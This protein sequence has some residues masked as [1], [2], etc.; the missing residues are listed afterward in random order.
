MHT[1]ER[2]FPTRFGPTTMNICYRFSLISF[3][4]VCVSPAEAVTLDPGD[5]IVL[6]TTNDAVVRVRPAEYDPN[7]KSANQTI[8]SDQNTPGNL[9]SNPYDVAIGDTALYVTDPTEDIIVRIDIATGAHSLVNVNVGGTPLTPFEPR[10]IAIDS[11]G[12]LVVADRGS[13]AVLE[14]DP[15]TGAAASFTPNIILGG[16]LRLALDDDDT[17]YLQDVSSIMRITPANQVSERVGSGADDGIVLDRES[18]LLYSADFPGIYRYDPETYDPQDPFVNRTEVFDDDAEALALA[19]NGDLFAT[20]SKNTDLLRINLSNG[21]SSIAAEGGA[22]LIPSGLAVVPGDSSVV[23]TLVAA[24]LPSSRSVEVGN[25]ATVFATMINTD[26]EAAS[27]CSVAIEDD[28]IGTLS[29]QTTDPATNEPVGAANTPADIAGG[30]GSQSFILS[31]TPSGPL[32]AEDV[33]FVFG[34]E[35]VV[36]AAVY[37][38]LN[39]LLLSASVTPVPDIVALAATPTGDGI[40]NVPGDDGANAFAVATV[41]VGAADT[42]TA[43]VDTGSAELPLDLFVCDTDAMGQCITPPATG[44]TVDIPANATPTFSVFVNG[45]GSV[46]FDAAGNRVFV[47]FKD[48]GGVTRGSTSVAVRTVQ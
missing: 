28:A 12:K 47:R 41:N 46:S 18:G 7:N 24:V 15:D 34:C 31:I 36:P 27:G 42:I 37:V 2:L 44:V 21:T 32:L 1:A 45:A 16:P 9:L 33:A 23:S 20:R 26:P 48:A 10:G 35:A 19:S 6:E 3:L 25:P 8:I 39:T 43:S 38:G 11:N 13:F 4:L 14:I 22:L 40:V 30:N 5:V 29:Y 17:I